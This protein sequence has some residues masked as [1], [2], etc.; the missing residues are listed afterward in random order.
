MRSRTKGALNALCTFCSTL[1]E[2]VE[3]LEWRRSDWLSQGIK[4]PV[5]SRHVRHSALLYGLDLILTGPLAV[6]MAR[7]ASLVLCL[8]PGVD[9]KVQDRPQQGC[10]PPKSRTIFQG[11]L[12]TPNSQLTGRTVACKG[13]TSDA[14]LPRWLVARFLERPFH[15]SEGLVFTCRERGSLTAKI[16]LHS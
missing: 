8:V 12:R 15:P 3:R 13:R 16:R 5:Q 14:F 4:G 9:A 7:L 10:A 11:D 1:L 2:A 6:V